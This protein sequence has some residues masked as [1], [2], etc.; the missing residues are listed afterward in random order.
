[1]NIR[2]LDTI[3]DEMLTVLNKHSVS[4]AEAR[5][6]GEALLIEIDRCNRCE[7]QSRTFQFHSVK[8]RTRR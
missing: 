1:M 6:V 7:Q 8:D 2:E 4:M 5:S 3:L